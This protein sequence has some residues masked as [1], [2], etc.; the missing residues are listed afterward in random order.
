[1]TESRA[2]ATAKFLVVDADSP[3]SIEFHGLI[4]FKAG[5]DSTFATLARL[6]SS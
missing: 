5:L 4:R 6:E 3:K 2:R 1:M